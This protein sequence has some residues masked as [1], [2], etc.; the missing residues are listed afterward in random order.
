MTNAAMTLHFNFE[1]CKTRRKNMPRNSANN[2]VIAQKNVHE[3]T[4]RSL[5][6]NLQFEK[7]NGLKKQPWFVLLANGSPLRYK[8]IKVQCVPLLVER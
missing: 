6:S 4:T 3:Q 2:T 7:A 8:F 5:K 1:R